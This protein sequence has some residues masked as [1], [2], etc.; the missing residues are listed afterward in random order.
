MIEK[1]SK[2][3]NVRNFFTAKDYFN[4]SMNKTKFYFI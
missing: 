1:I 3:I 2:Q 4:S